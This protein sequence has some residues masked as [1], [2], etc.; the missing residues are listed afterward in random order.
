M[1]ATIKRG[2]KGDTLT[3]TTNM[4]LTGCTLRLLARAKYGTGDLIELDIDNSTDYAAG[5]VVHV[6]DGTLPMITGGYNLEVEATRGEEIFTFP[7][8]GFVTLNIVP[9]LG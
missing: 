2:D 8:Q 1:A 7:T 3:L 5:T 6:T 4:D 9:D